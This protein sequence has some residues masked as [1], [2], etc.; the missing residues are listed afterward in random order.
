MPNK[1]FCDKGRIQ[2]VLA[3]LVSYTTKKSL[4]GDIT[5]KVSIVSSPDAFL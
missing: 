3:T 1:I 5:V 2:Q 4:E